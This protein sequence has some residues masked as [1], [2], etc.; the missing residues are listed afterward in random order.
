MLPIDLE[1]ELLVLDEMLTNEGSSVYSLTFKSPV[2]LFFLRHFGCVFCKESLNDISQRRQNIEQSG[3]KIVFVH[4]SDDETA[5]EYLGNFNLQGA[6]YVC[7]PGQQFYR[8]FGLSN[9]KQFSW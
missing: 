1:Q 2:M 7:D 4:M 8:A 6:T 5:I 9:V 3:I